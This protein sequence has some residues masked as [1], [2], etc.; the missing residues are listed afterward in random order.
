MDDPLDRGEMLR[1]IQRYQVARMRAT[2]E[3]L[4][5]SPVHGRL[6]EFFVADLYGPRERS[7]AW[8]ASLESFVARLK[9]LVP[10]WI[11]DGALGLVELQSLSA[12][13]DDRLARALFTAG[14]SIHFSSEEFEAAYFRCDDHADRVRQIALSE[15][16]A[17][18]AFALSR[19]RSVGFLLGAARKLHRHA[20]VDSLIAILERGHDALVGVGE[21]DSFLAAMRAGE[22]AYLDGIYA[23]MRG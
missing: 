10:A 5:R 13:L 6:C 17:S 11:S 14:C 22:T 19:H 16:C 3:A 2:H 1:A 9:S 7:L 12:Q 4:F 18:Y 8:Q 20:S 23:K 15:A 21:I